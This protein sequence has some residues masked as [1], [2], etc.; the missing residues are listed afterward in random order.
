MV[1]N[2]DRETI[3]CYQVTEYLGL[4]YNVI[5]TIAGKRGLSLDDEF[6]RKI[7]IFETAVLAILN[8]TDENAPCSEG[9]RE[10][11]I[12]E[13]GGPDYIEWKCQNCPK[14]KK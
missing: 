6:F 13:M 1:K 2:T 12:Y 9:M 14:N 10:K 8:G 7:S 11:C 3:M 5:M 4:D